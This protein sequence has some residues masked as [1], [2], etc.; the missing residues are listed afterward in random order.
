M[1]DHLSFRHLSSGHDRLLQK[2]RVV[3][4]TVAANA[5]SGAQL[6]FTI[7]EE[8]GKGGFG[9]VYG[10]RRRKDGMLSSRGWVEGRGMWNAVG[11]GANMK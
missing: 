7:E 4:P 6:D 2:G 1:L 3:R 8:L 5:P 11:L 10:G 9:T